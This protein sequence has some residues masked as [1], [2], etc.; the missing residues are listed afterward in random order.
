M[1]RNRKN[2]HKKHKGIKAFAIILTIMVVITSGALFYLNGKLSKIKI[3]KIDDENLSI[4]ENS[5]KSND[6]SEDN[7][8]N[9]L[10]MGIDID[11]EVND[12]NSADS[13][14]IATIDKTHKKLKLTS[15]MRDSYVDVEGHGNTKLKYSYSYGGPE[16]LIKTVNKNFNMNVKDY[17]KVDINNLGK[18]IDYLG[19]VSINVQPDEVNLI[20]S[21]MEGAS[22]VYKF[23]YAAIKKSGLQVLNGAQA[24]AYCRIRYVGNVDFQRTERQRTV[25]TEISKKLSQKGLLGLPKASD[26]I[27]PYVETSLSKTE[28]LSL[29][30]YVLINKITTPEQFRVPTDD[31]YH[32]STINGLYYMKWDKEPTIDKLHNFIFGS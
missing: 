28:L 15:I 16:L 23:K 22:K 27:L 8:V 11:K 13:I 17:V 1:T 18:I 2:K 10:L 20:N 7:F 12:S 24:V 3:N 4:D 30:S 31:N 25:L 26:N 29:G 9:I 14:M 19:G 6:K 21:Y 5:F 32:D